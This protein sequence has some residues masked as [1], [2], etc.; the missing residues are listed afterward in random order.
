MTTENVGLMDLRRAS[1]PVTIGEQSVT[2]RA[3][4]AAAIA[5][6]LVK[7]P[8]A[9]KMMKGAKVEFTFEALLTG[10]PDFV[11]FLIAA[12]FDLQDDP[13]AIKHAATLGLSDQLALIEGI[14]DA[15]LEGGMAPFVAKV[16]KILGGFGVALPKDIG[17]PTGV[18]ATK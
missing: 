11:A 14:V 10:A 12:G 1:R 15:S 6:A 17:S 13:E 3:I 7:F 2:V 4:S 5:T 9:R 16:T 8:T 18:P